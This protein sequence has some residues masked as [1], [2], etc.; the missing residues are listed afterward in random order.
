MTPTGLTLDGIV[1]VSKRGGR[2]VL[3]SPAQQEADI[4]RWADDHGHTIAMVHV[5]IDESAGHGAHPAIEAA[6][7]RALDGD[8]DGCVAAYISRFA[9]T[10]LYGLETVND[11]LAAGKYFFSPDCPFDLKTPDGERFLTDKLSDARYQWRMYKENFDRNVT[12]AI[13]RGVHINVPFGYQRSE[14]RGSPLAPNDTEA[15]TVIEAARLRA[16]GWSWP[17]IAREL[18]AHWCPPRVT[19]RKGVEWQAEWNHTTVHQMLKQDVYRGWAYSKPHVNKAA[20]PP[21]IDPDTWA[22][23]EAARGV[24]HDRPAEGYE[25]TGLVR[26]AGCGYAMMHN[27]DNGRRYYR[28]KRRT[29]SKDRCPAGTNIPAAELETLVMQRFAREHLREEATGEAVTQ[30]E[31]QALAEVEAANAHMQAVVDTWTDVRA[32]TGKLTADQATRQGN[33]IRAASARVSAAEGALYDVRAAA[34]GHDM[35][36][37]LTIAAFND[38]SASERRHYLSLMYRAV[39]CR[40]ADGWRED[41]GN[42]FTILTA[43]GEAPVNGM[44]LIREVLES[45]GLPE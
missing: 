15:P 3:R 24:K 36:G 16:D 33:D 32:V 41:V 21:L 34:R 20:H 39:V 17:R 44:P 31:S 27:T 28:C 7:A 29:V 19:K 35:L 6:K 23:V 1:R 14:G 18:N 5:A 37:K 25:L 4:R 12:E 40:P 11:L 45:D 38:A 8:T 9:R 22:R 42:R 2:E 13:E 10:V 30:D 43:V 26:C